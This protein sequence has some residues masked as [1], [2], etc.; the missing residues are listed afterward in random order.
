MIGRKGGAGKNGKPSAGIFRV[1]PYL[2][3]SINCNVD[4]IIGSLI[5]GTCIGIPNFPH[6]PASS[7]IPPPFSEHSFFFTIPPFRLQSPPLR[8]GTVL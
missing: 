1:S 7:L 6:L 3:K 4:I 2:F 8:N 5:T